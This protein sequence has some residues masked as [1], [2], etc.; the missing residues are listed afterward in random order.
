MIGIQSSIALL[1]VPANLGVHSQNQYQVD[2]TFVTTES[3]P[4]DCF[5]LV[6]Q[7]LIQDVDSFSRTSAC[8]NKPQVIPIRR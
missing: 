2:F 8:A 1:G 6:D 3:A 4:L 7:Y 5:G